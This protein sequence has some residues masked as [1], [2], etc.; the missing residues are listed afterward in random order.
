MTDM[1]KLDVDNDAL[2]AT[3]LRTVQ[4]TQQRKAPLVEIRC[5][6]CGAVLGC[7]D[8]LPR[9]RLF[10]SWWEVD[11]SPPSGW[12]GTGAYVLR[13]DRP[14]E[15]IPVEEHLQERVAAGAMRERQYG[16]PL[17]VSGHVCFA[18]IDDGLAEYPALFVRC[19]QHGDMV[20]DRAEAIR[21]LDAAV[22]P[23]KW[24]VAPQFPRLAYV[25][26]REDM[27]SEILSTTTT[28]TT[29]KIVTTWAPADSSRGIDP[30]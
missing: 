28:T 29:S 6:G 26:P 7:L 12:A 10:A 17:A 5:S 20:L 23:A 19:A 25:E 14:G 3:T 9:G 2:W 22:K 27:L 11:A 15:R 13:S 1:L 8:K 24:A 21:R 4:S 30:G 18:L 16:P